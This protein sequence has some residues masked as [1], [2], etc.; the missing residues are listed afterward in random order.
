MTND[1]TFLRLESEVRSYCRSFPVVLKSA[2]DHLVRDESGRTYIDFFAGAGSLNYGHNNRRIV[3]RVVAY[4]RDDG[5][6][7][8]LDFYTV[9]KREFMERFEAVIL[10]PRRLSYKLQFPGPTGTNAVEAAMKLARKVTGR[11]TIAAFTNG[12]HGMSLGALAATANPAKRAG[13][14]VPL[15][16]VVRLPYDGFLGPTVDSMRLIETMLEDPGGGIDRPAAFLIETVQGEGGLGAASVDWLRRLAALARRLDILL[17]VDDIQAGCGRTGGFFSFEQA[18]LA[19]D[20]VCLSKS[21]GGIGLPMS[22]LLLRPEIDRWQPGEHNGTFRGNNLA[23]VAANAALDYWADGA[24]EQHIARRS[25]M[26]SGGLRDI[27]RRHSP[28]SGQLRGR[29]MMQGIAWNDPEAAPQV[30]QAAFRRGLIAETCGP[31][32]EVIKLLPPLTIEDDALAQG[33]HILEESV[34]EVMGT[35][36]ATA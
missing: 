27:I 25:Q 29:G 33:L 7:H 30:S 4:L 19:P 9:A 36:R 1:A 11:T 6:L 28:Q 20:I 35:H 8:A 31:R 32:D 10:K 21:I 23:F 22:L 16:H 15:G 17:I 5:I 14:G 2:R 24:F 18:A 26:I 34:A 12:F 3:E 13:A